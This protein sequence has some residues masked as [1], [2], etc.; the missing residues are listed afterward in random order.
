MMFVILSHTE[1]RWVSDKATHIVTRFFYNRDY[2][3]W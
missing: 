2:D 3:L 1:L